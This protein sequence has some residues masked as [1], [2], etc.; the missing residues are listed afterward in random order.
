[1]I[2]EMVMT[3]LYNVFEFLTIPIDIPDLPSRVADTIG[4]AYEY[5]YMGI[6]ILQNYT[7]YHYLISLFMIIISVEVGIHVYQFVMYILKKI[8]MANIK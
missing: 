2:I 3:V 4:V 6:G 1:M 8:P 5:I 7:H